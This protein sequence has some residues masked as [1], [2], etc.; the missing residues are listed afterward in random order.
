[1]VRFGLVS[2]ATSVALGDF[3]A[4]LA[5]VPALLAHMGYS[6]DA[7]READADAA[8]V[9]RAA[10]RDPAAMVVLFERLAARDAGEGA[11]RGGPP[12]AF[13]SHPADEARVRFF[14]EAAQPSR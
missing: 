2:A 8:F 10:G 5:G 13:A 3:S 14:R 7:E 1:M 11:Q 9:L 12:I 4:L 6:R